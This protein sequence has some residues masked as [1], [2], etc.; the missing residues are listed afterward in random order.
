MIFENGL[1]TILSQILT[2]IAILFDYETIN[3]Y[4]KYIMKLFLPLYIIQYYL[5]SIL[6]N[7]KLQFNLNEL[8]NRYNLSQFKEYLKTDNNVNN[9][10]KFIAKNI[11]LTN[12]L[13][14]NNKHFDNEINSILDKVGVSNDNLGDFFDKIFMPDYPEEKSPK[15]TIDSFF[16]QFL[17][18]M[19][20]NDFFAEKFF[21]IFENYI[22]SNN[23][24]FINPNLLGS[25]LPITYNFIS[26]PKLALDF[27]YDFFEIPCSYC[28][29]IGCPSFIC[30]TCKAKICNTEYNKCKG[31][32]L[33]FD[34]N[35]EC[36]MGRSIY[37]NTYNYKIVLMDYI[38]KIEKDIPFYVNKFGE[39]VDNIV[40]TKDI[41]LNEDEIKIALK[42]FI[43]Y[44]WINN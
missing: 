15:S 42:T 32:D 7:Y 11:K 36:G 37:I 18:K 39:S 28:G 13:I 23:N 34:H 31:S 26:L 24:L 6:I 5:R 21:T 35:R 22:A 10:I 9:T 29:K 38:D 30:L 41:K 3:G 27:Q 19:E 25:C 33:L 44:S 4:E 40:T 1:K 12:H 16:S 2:I 17:P 20:I 43:N 14:G 8:K